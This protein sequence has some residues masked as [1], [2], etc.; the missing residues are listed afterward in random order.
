VRGKDTSRP[1]GVKKNKKKKTANGEG[2][3]RWKK[4]RGK[5]RI[6]LTAGGWRSKGPRPGLT[7]AKGSISIR[8]SKTKRKKKDER[9]KGRKDPAVLE[10]GGE[11]DD[12]ATETQAPY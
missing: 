10:R 11:S 8:T 3:A 6:E 9:E 12:C 4:K 5:T 2:N 7:K 1:K